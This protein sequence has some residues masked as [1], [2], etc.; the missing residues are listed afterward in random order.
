MERTTDTLLVDLVIGLAAGLV[1]T[2]VTGFAQ[3]ALYR[4]MPESIK[5]REEEVRPGPPPRVAAQKTAEALG[6]ELDEKQLKMAGMAVH[7][8][9]GLAWGPVY[10]LL[11][12]YSRMDPLGA[13]LVTGAAFSLIVDEALTPAFGFSAPSQDYPM[14]THVRGFLGHLIYGAV[15]ALT[16]EAL[17]RLTGMAP[18]VPERRPAQA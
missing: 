10:G 5:R 3:E 8:G 7:Y 11:R 14:V 13:G 1:A 16:A 9:L 15:A 4:P 18:P 12:R 2:K 6:V 17:Y